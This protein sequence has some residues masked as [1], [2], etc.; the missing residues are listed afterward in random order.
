MTIIERIFTNNHYQISIA[1]KSVLAQL[2]N[3]IIVPL[4]V[5]Y[6]IKENIY[7]KGGLTE[8][9]FILAIFNSFLPPLIRMIDPYAIFVHLRYVYYDRPI[10][11]IQLMRS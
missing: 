9:I 7:Q 4:I 5:N 11:K 1:I 2:V 3:S 8:D 6:N 10:N